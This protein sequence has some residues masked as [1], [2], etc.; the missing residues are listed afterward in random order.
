MI[1]ATQQA[2]S[3]MIDRAALRGVTYAEEQR[4]VRERLSRM[5]TRAVGDTIAFVGDDFERRRAWFSGFIQAV[6]AASFVVHGGVMDAVRGWAAERHVEL[7]DGIAVLDRHRDSVVTWVHLDG[8][9]NKLLAKALAAQIAGDAR[10]P[11]SH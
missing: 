2:R 7:V 3:L 11:P 1:V 9:G 5:A 10:H 6:T 8:R 4:I